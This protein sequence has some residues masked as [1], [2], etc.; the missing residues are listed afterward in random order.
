MRTLLLILMGLL[1]LPG[2]YPGTVGLDPR[3]DDDDDDDD[4]TDDDDVSDDD[5]SDSV[6][7]DDDSADDAWWDD[8]E[9]VQGTDADAATSRS[10]TF[11][12][13]CNASTASASPVVGGLALL[14][15]GLVRRRD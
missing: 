6:G 5:D 10:T 7:D 14:I 3:R 15:L 12:C 13:A 8:D 9:G 1:L 11:G 2:C 4:A